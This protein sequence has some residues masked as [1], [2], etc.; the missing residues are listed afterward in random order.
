MP[1]RGFQSEALPGSFSFLQRK[2]DPEGVR[3][4]PSASALWRNLVYSKRGAGGDSCG[5]SG[6]R[7]LEEM[8][9][10]RCR[11]DSRRERGRWRLGPGSV[12]G[13]RD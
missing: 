13:G 12:R 9:S 2:T 8:S 7:V 4:N 6:H 11:G 3:Q 5:S 1:D 10:P